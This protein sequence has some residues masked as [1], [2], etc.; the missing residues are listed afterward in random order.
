MAA[1]DSVVRDCIE[2]SHACEG[3]RSPTGS[4]YFASVLF[5]S[6]C[7]RAVSIAVMTPYSPW[8]K[9]LVEHWDYASM[10]SLTRAL[11]EV[12][13]AF[14][15][16]C[17]ETCSDDE[18]QCRW[19]IFNIHDCRSRLRLFT[20][21]P[22]SSEDVSSFQEQ[23][24]EL[25]ERLT[26]NAHFGTVQANQQKQFLNGDR[27]YLHSLEEIASRAGVDL[28]TFRWLYKF[29]SSHVHGLPM[30]FYRMGQQERGRGVY[31]DTEERYT[32]LCLSFVAS[33]LVK[34]RDEMI[35]K[36]G[37]S[38]KQ[39]QQSAQTDSSAPGESAVCPWG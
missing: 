8:S 1:L 25:Q 38:N 4:H 2:V 15:Y 19:N 17:V 5:T 12:R 28:D 6:L 16:L 35:E 32:S 3:I 10:A 18:W 26:S 20:E 29:L 7:T 11:L 14:F 22:G 24:K 33:L 9:K 39:T 30:S 13:L 27:A 34:S 37:I 23:L 21:L 36:F 31:S